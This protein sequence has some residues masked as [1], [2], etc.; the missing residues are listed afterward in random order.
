MYFAIR[1]KQ[2]QHYK[3]SLGVHLNSAGHPHA[4]SLICV[5][6]CAPASFPALL[7]PLP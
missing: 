7:H 2:M 3:C 1:A 5:E 6:K 4:F